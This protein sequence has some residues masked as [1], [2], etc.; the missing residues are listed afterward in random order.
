MI[1][2][3]DTDELGAAVDISARPMSKFGDRVHA[4]IFVVQAHDTRLKEGTYLDRM[5]KI[6]DHFRFDGMLLCLYFNQY[7]CIEVLQ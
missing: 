4:V 6:R 1:R 2:A 5:K 7:C 3:V